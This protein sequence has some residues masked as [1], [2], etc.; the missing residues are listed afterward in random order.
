LERVAD[1]IIQKIKSCGVDTIFLVNGRGVLYI[2]DALAKESSI[3]AVSTYHEQG[4][5]Y[6]AMAYAHAK[7][8]IGACI[9]STGCAAAN[10]VA[11]ALCAYQDNLPV[12]FITGQN[13]LNETTR[14]TGVKIRT[15]G[16]Q[17]ADIID[18]VKPV[19]KYAVM[20]TDAAKAVYEV[21]KALCIAQEGRKGPVWIDIP[22]DI[23]NARIEPD[24]LE[25]YNSN[26]KPA[27]TSDAVIKTVIA[28]LKS[29]R[30]PVIL[31]GG[32][33]RSSG[34]V[35]EF[36]K[37][38]EKIRLPVIFTPIA[39]DVYGSS[40][41]LSI[42]A[43]GS[44][45]GS[46]AGNFAIQN[47]D[48]I[49]ALGTKLCSQATGTKENFA[50]EAKITVIDIDP[51]EH[52]KTSVKIDK[53]IISDAKAF[54]T[55]MIEKADLKAPESWIEKCKH[56]KEVFAVKNE[57]FIVED[58]ANN[59]IDLYHFCDTL[60]SRLSP[61][62]TVITDAGL[63]ELIV[64]SSIAY[65]EEQRCL[66]PASQGAMGYALP[67]ILGAWYAGKKNLVC[68]AGDGSFMMNMQELQTIS[69]HKIPVKLIVINNNMYAIIRKRQHDL[70][71]KRTI[72]NDPSDGLAEP[73]FEKIAGAFDF[74]YQKIS[75]LDELAKGLDKLFNNE[76]C[77]ICEVISTPEQKYLHESYGLNEKKQLVH[78]PIEDLS[79]FMP[80]EQL[81]EEMIIKPLE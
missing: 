68:I 58:K 23:Q 31:I 47:S 16:S 18:V 66:F 11:A 46:R 1:Y 55:M 77:Q 2:T 49:L 81:H 50:R 60:S 38:I 51:A 10:G 26:S 65:K 13:M 61:D 34:A 35:K 54:I 3:K 62:T 71:R 72:G 42:G 73:D 74:G 75:T 57:P 76:G 19:T 53:I 41:E 69:A 67:A 32:G 78:R 4:A 59:V 8:G 25:Q 39:A 70:F 33:V 14:Y 27:V 24:E 5:S 20:L 7:D 22:L 30:R 48:Y 80:R 17:E 64:P 45:G 29:A 63:E 43:T 21:E 79:P 40:H 12:V 9:L 36:K 28:E 52:T 6:A 44:L 56:W 37:L 15:Y